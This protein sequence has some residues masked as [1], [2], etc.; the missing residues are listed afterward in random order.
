MILI[1]YHYIVQPCLSKSVFHYLFH[2][3]FYVLKTGAVWQEMEGKEDFKIVL[4]THGNTEHMPILS[5]VLLP[6]IFSF[7]FQAQLRRYAFILFQ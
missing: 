6:F 3:H 7:F 5:V 4:N 2:N 1:L